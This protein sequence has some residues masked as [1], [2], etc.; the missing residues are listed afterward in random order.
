M[1]G[2]AIISNGREFIDGG[3][4][5]FPSVI[6][7]DLFDREFPLMHGSSVYVQPV[8]EFSGVVVALGHPEMQ[9]GL[10]L[11]VS[12]DLARSIA[13]WLLNAANAIDGGRG[14]Q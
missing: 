13:A 11:G 8:L 7:I 2:A 4:P 1:T 3:A 14:A 10:F 5:L 12:P 6:T 9:H